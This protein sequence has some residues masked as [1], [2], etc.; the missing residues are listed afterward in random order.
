VREEP[1]RPSEVNPSIPGALDAVVLKALSK[2]PLNRYQSAAEMR[3][4][5]VRVRSG[6]SP[7]A[8]LVMSEDERTAMLGA[9]PSTG[10]TRR[11]NGGRHTPPPSAYEDDYY[12]DE[13]ERR[14]P[15]RT[16]GIIAGVLVALGLIAFVAFQ[17]F[18]DPPAPEQITVPQVVGLE[19]QAARNAII[20]LGLRVAASQPA[21]STVAQRGQVLSSTPQSGSSVEARTEVTLVVGSGPASVTVPRLEDQTVAEAERILEEAGLTLGPSTNQETDDSSEVGRIIESTPSA[22]VSAPGGSPVAVVVG[23]ERTTIPVPDVSGR[24]ADDAED[25]LRQAGLRVT[26]QEVD[27]TGND[28][29]VIG[30]NPQANTQVARNSQV[31]LQ[32]SNGN[33]IEMPDVTG[34]QPQDAQDRLND[35]GLTNVR[36]QPREVTNEEQDNLVLEQSVEPGEAVAPDQQIVLTYG[37]FPGGF[38]G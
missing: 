25:A 32:I 28:G 12:D 6:Q 33:A 16:I 15:A 18:A 4:D 2:N 21:E 11:I 17:I 23:S 10:P 9:A 37:R 26:R 38:F 36:L 5:L 13:E 30:T 35:L 3:S 7:L 31:V 27:G 34:D 24:E 22:G 1:R 20:G 8:P 14:S 19:E 29:D